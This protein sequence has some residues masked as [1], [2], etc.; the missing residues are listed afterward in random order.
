LITGAAGLI[1]GILRERLEGY[2]VVSVDRRR[3]VEGVARVDSTRLRRLQRV[4][5]GVDVVVD[6]AGDASPD[7]SWQD[8]HK[9]N[10]P[11]TV[12]LLE[13]AVRAGVS[14]VVYAS[15]NHV[16]GM[17]EREEPYASIAAGRYDGLT[18]DRIP[19]LKADAPV[20]PDGP[21]GL[22]KVLGE[23]AGR[24]YAEEFGL[25]VLCLRI[26]T[27]TR[28]GRP[29]TPRHFATLLSHDDLVRLVRAA[30]D[31]P[32]ELAY[33][34][35]YGVSANTWRFWDIERASTEFGYSPRDDAERWR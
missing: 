11:A 22:G 16:T 35:Y 4:L 1:G 20:R 3:G 31:A 18:P 12:N 33:G 29:I 34:I 21:Y 26:G 6:L 13:V 7:A 25:S 8:V 30:I 9:N 15:S 14:R 32:Q 24:Y 27:V 19:R 2:E 10:L 5:D 28:S 17:Y 23:A